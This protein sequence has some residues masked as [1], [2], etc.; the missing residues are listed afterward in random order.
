M[1]TGKCFS[2]QS[3]NARQD[4]TQHHTP[5][6]GH[7]LAT[8]RSAWHGAQ[9]N[10]T[11]RSECVPSRRSKQKHKLRHIAYPASQPCCF[12]VTKIRKHLHLIT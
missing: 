12:S 4:L 9:S 6:P 2:K 11:M 3:C 1:N 5:A 7:S 8:C 10:H